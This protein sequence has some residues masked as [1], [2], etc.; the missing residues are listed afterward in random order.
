[1]IKSAFGAECVQGTAKFCYSIPADASMPQVNDQL[2]KVVP[3][4]VFSYVELPWGVQGIDPELSVVQDVRARFLT[5]LTID[6]SEGS[7]FF[8]VG[9]GY[10]GEYD[11]F[12]RLLQPEFDIAVES[13]IGIYLVAKLAR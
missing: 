8:R 7:L 1:M 6:L 3:C 9:E 5:D 10:I 2:A 12:M 13:Q 4:D 11:Y